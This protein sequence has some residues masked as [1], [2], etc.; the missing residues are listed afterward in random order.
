M[1]HSRSGLGREMYY[2]KSNIRNIRNKSK[3]ILP[4]E[5]GA[6]LEVPEPVCDGQPFGPA[7]PKDALRQEAVGSDISPEIQFEWITAQWAFR[8][9]RGREAQASRIAITLTFLMPQE[10][11]TQIR[12]HKI[13][14]YLTDRL[15]EFQA[16]NDLQRRVLTWAG[17]N[18]QRWV[19]KARVRQSR[20]EPV[21]DY[22]RRN[23]PDLVM[24]AEIAQPDGDS[25]VRAYLHTPREMITLEFTHPLTAAQQRYYE[26]AARW[27]NLPQ[28]R[29]DFT[30]WIRYA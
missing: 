22:H 20:T 15:R 13:T 8:K 6:D 7:S 19:G 14:F 25:F 17:L 30:D 21:Q 26:G 29:D 11:G 23:I 12:P 9:H 24:T 18:D 5:M 10:I 3:P 4:G 27:G 2:N 28:V 16:T 1:N